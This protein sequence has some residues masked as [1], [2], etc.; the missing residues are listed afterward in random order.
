LH[1]RNRPVHSRLSL[2]SSGRRFW[3]LLRCFDMTRSI[4]WIFGETRIRV[5]CQW[6][7]DRFRKFPFPIFCLFSVY[8]Y[9]VP[10]HLYLHHR[11]TCRTARPSAPDILDQEKGRKNNSLNGTWTP[12][13]VFQ[14]AGAD[15]Y[16]KVT[17]SDE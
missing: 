13:P 14:F 5:S 12:I 1:Q 8:L 9:V 16:A 2:H 3:S 6:W 10:L 15:G 4:P 17:K 11:I 7:T